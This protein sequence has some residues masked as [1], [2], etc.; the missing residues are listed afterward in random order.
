MGEG[1]REGSD[2]GAPIGFHLTQ[3]VS[4][5]IPV[6]TVAVLVVGLHWRVGGVG[7]GGVGGGEGKGGVGGGEGGEGVMNI[8]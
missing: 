4:V 1:G 5:L 3:G 7:G 2:M 6:S 8:H